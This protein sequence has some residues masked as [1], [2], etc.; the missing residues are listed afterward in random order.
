VLRKK[1]YE[2][3]LFLA[4]GTAIAA[5]IFY[6]AQSTSAAKDGLALC[7][8]VIVPSLFPFF[9]L[10]TLVVET[11][12]TRR[13]GR[14]LEPVMRP[15][16]GVG[17]GCVA[18][19]ALG[20]VGGYPVGA[21]TVIALYDSGE[22]T[23]TEAERLLSFCNNSGPAFIF[24]VVGAGVFASGKIGLLLYLAH[25][26]ASVAVGVMF[27]NW[28]GNRRE[29][30]RR[31]RASSAPQKRFVAA[32]TDSVKSSFTS[33]LNICG[34]VIFFT[35]FIRLLFLSGAIPALAALIGRVFHPLGLDAK[36]SERL[37][38]GFIEISSGVW[39]LKGAEGQLAG[40]VAMA[41]FMLGWA[42]LSVHSQVLSFIGESGL[43]V[44]TYIIGKL[45]QGIISAGLVFVISR[46]FVLSAPAS[47]LA[48][49]VTVL[50]NIG[51]TQAAAISTVA[52]TAL[53]AVCA[54]AQR[55]TVDN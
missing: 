14:L 10:S 11:G 38:T 50:A 20:F 24:G 46:V 33:T 2:A 39:T 1:I 41:S 13:L 21:K 28:G 44:R 49:Q 53:Y 15:L 8:N 25:T 32:F 47:Y 36:W 48:D 37:L 17:G 23:A 34:F 30:P 54:A 3:C 16:F 18:A 43:S 40:G 55:G 51:F 35:V 22:C 52:A 7:A 9:V 26:L 42:G 45:L 19:F 4:I 31:A 6:P 27:R 29:R 12:V 5:L